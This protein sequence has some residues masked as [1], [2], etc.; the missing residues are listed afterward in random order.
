MFKQSPR[1]GISLALLLVASLAFQSI[2]SMGGGVVFGLGSLPRQSVISDKR[3]FN[4]TVAENTFLNAPIPKPAPEPPALAPTIVAT[5]DDGLAAATTVAP[6]GT[7][8]Y[9]V[10][11]KNNG[12]TSPAD[13][14]TNVQ[15]SDTIDAH[16]T[17]VAGSRVAAVSDK[18]NT[19][20]NVQ[21][22]IPDGATDLLGNDF[23]PDSGTNAGMTVTAETK[24]STSCTGG[25]S[26]NVTIN[27]NG[28]FTYDP[29][30]GFSG[31]DTFTYTAISGTSSASETVTITVA[32]EIWFINNNAGACPGAP[33]DGR[34]SHPFT[35]L[36]AFTGANL[37]GAGQPGDNDWI[38]STRA[39]RTTPVQRRFG[40]GRN[41]WPGC[42]SEPGDVTTFPAP[43][44]TDPLPVM[45]SGNATM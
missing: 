12:G 30:V 33:C 10:N 1:S 14:A 25:C 2:P 21:I 9:T 39:R 44:G 28:S 7:I 3:D 38:L 18:Y 13:D 42:D 8:T 24:S 20:G 37:G 36:A 17:L 4:A 32:N 16:T 40:T 35:S 6:G 31:T 45:N 5:K 15:F 22:S 11:I 29:P 34:L 41:Y 23:D 27:A 43:S 26:N 19:T